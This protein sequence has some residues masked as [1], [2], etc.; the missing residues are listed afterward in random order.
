V[1]LVVVIVDTP[2]RQFSTDEVRRALFASA[3]GTDYLRHAYLEAV[4]GRTMFS[5]Y[6]L[7]TNESA[8][9]RMAEQLCRRTMASV[10]T[11]SDWRVESTRIGFSP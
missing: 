8:A 4:Y 10:C 6:L 2:N 11:V 3:A 9:L 5:L 7:A 1:Y